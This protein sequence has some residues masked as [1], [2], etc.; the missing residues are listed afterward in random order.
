MLHG[1]ELDGVSSLAEAATKI[2]ALA[3][4][5]D[6][7]HASGW[8]L[9]SP[10][11]DGRLHARRASRRQ[12]ASTQAV[13]QGASAGT[14]RQLQ[15]RLRIVDESSTE[16]SAD[17]ALAFDSATATPWLAA[18]KGAVEQIAG[19]PLDADRLQIITAQVNAQEL[20][21]RRWAA[22]AARVGPG[23]DLV[24][25]GNALHAHSVID[26]VV[27][28]TIE[29]LGFKHAADRAATLLDGAAAYRRLADAA[30]AM[31][32]A[33]GRLS[34]VDDGFLFVEY[35]HDAS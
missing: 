32:R 2:N 16:D 30:I 24:A 28:R 22:V 20:G 3:G 13:T 6:A 31:D 29:V 34:V 21:D 19:P 11:L 26:G 18:R 8:W 17:A 25:E 14:A 5:L 33:G 1:W 10:M 23:V 35:A 27:V 9:E 7:A 15:V 12:R 4:E